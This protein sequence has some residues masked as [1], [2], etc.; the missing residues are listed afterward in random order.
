MKLTV[1]I[2]SLA[3]MLGNMPSVAQE[4][5]LAPESEGA[6]DTY[7]TVTKPAE[8]LLPPELMLY[9]AGVIVPPY[10]DIT[11]PSGITPTAPQLF[12]DFQAKPL[13]AWGGGV[14]YG[15]SSTNNLPGLGN[16]RSTSIGIKQQFG[17][18]TVTGAISGYKYHIN[19]NTYND[20]GISGRVSYQINPHFSVSVYGNY[21]VNHVQESPASAP[22]TNSSCFGGSVHYHASETFGAEM[23]VRRVFDPEQ[24]KWK[25]VPVVEPTVNVGGCE[26]GID[27]GGIIYDIIDN[28]NKKKHERHEPVKPLPDDKL[29]SKKGSIPGSG[30]HLLPAKAVKPQ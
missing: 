6:S 11:L 25:T 19:R 1:L 28:N 18:F 26:V 30:H 9:R 3:I 5:A 4:V 13:S 21:S 22:Y 15:F 7:S 2:L 12:S 8:D 20:Y 23:G 24:N 17:R 10:S 14:A 27:V 16:F 29:D